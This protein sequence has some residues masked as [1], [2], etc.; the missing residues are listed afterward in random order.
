[1]GKYNFNTIINREGS[2]CVKYD[3]R[4]AYFG[5]ASLLPMWVADMDFATPDFIRERI[6]QRI[7][8]PVFGYTFRSDAYFESIAGWLLRRHGYKVQKEWMS[9]SPGIVPAINMAVLA[10][11]KAGDGIIVQPPVYFPFFGAV[12]D[13][14]RQL[15]YNQ[16]VYNGVSYEMDFDLLEQ[17]TKVAKMLIL[18]NP[19]NPVG[20]SWNTQELEMVAD[21]C[22]RN[23]VII[24]SDEIHNDLVLP[25]RRHQTMAGIDPEVE[26]IVLTAHAASK[27]FNLAGLAASTMIISNEQL[28]TP[29]ETLLKSL[30]VDM[31]NLFGFE[32]TRAAFEEGD[33][34]LSELLDYLNDNV[35]T[36]LAF[37][38]SRSLGIKAVPP[39]A[40][41][42]LWL[43]FGGCG[44]SQEEIKH[45]LINEAGVGLNNGPDFGPGGEGFM[46]INVA[47][48]KALLIDGLIRIENAFK[49]IL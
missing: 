31:G 43:D 10:L 16:L 27:T 29:Y 3:L 22:L 18:C 40:T 1:M 32:A 30:H 21:I 26:K 37:F 36:T 6:L 9:F 39:E 44:L 20:R 17:Q 38:R 45:K 7:S 4:Q 24:L 8:H 35:E 14:G 46:R 12:K 15:I 25:G 42:L 48:P 33:Q 19:H 49:Q 28:R 41:Y 23:D 2:S 5:N 13:H 47:C 34:W 11:S